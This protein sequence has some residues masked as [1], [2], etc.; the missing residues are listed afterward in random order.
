[1]SSLS[2]E[3]KDAREARDAGAAATDGERRKAERALKEVHQ[4]AEIALDDGRRQQES[5]MAVAVA[6]SAAASARADQL[7]SDCAAAVEAQAVAERAAAIAVEDAG[8]FAG[9]L[10]SLRSGDADA[11]A[12]AR[13][14]DALIARAREETGAAHQRGR[15]ELASAKAAHVEGLAAAK[16]EHRQQL[17]EI[18]DQRVEVER[19]RA[20][21]H[22]TQLAAIRAECDTQAAGGS[23]AESELRSQLGTLKDEHSAAAAAAEEEMSAAKTK[24]R[25][26]LKKLT[27]QLREARAA[28]QKEKDVLAAELAESTT[29]FQVGCA[30]MS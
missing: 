8:R 1:M 7:E 27:A 23:A 22:A 29:R 3:L 6:D 11:E 28:G 26:A 20:D 25:D 9:E 13:E 14:K 15:S 12:A 30:T 4:A 16:A 24:S 21:E 10:E 18:D 2:G 17:V 5:A 19:G